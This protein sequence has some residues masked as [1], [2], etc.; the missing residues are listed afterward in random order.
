MPA[1]NFLNLTEKNK[2]QEALKQEEKAEIRERILMF[3]LLNDGKTQQEIS[4]FI[5]CSLRTV[6][7]WCVHGD[8][9]NLE[10]LEDGRTKGNYRKA[11]AKYIESLL[12]AIERSPSEYNYEFG[13]WTAARLG[14]HLEQETGIS[15]SGSQ[16]ARILAQKK[17]VYIWGKYSLED[18]Q[19]R[20]LR[21]QFKEKLE[22]YIKSAKEHPECLQVWFWDEC[23]FSLRVI[24]RR[25]WT[26]KGKRK[27]IKGQRRR[28]R[29][30][31]MGALRHSDKKRWCFLV[32]KG[33]SL[34]FYQQVKNFHDALIH[35]W[36]T[37]GN[38]SEDFEEKSA[39]IVI[40]LDN[41]SFH[42]KQEIV[43]QISSDF[44]KLKLEY[45]PP[46]SPDYNLIELVWHSAKEYIAHRD[47]DSKEQLEKTVNRL[48]NEGD[49]II[50]WS[51]KVKNKGNAVNAI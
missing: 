15:L 39:Q 42:K 13:R 2:L 22:G 11:T 19:D 46:Y 35:E 45:L 33:D 16:I 40:I 41:A 50:Q 8:P 5:G 24:R 3:L 9:H 7:Y 28:G 25:A 43:N 6:A 51:K 36:I 27:Q 17:Y 31:V 49:L 14:K 10:S 21:K 48:L 38:K 32:D 23:G 29:V 20:E 12:F 26:K 1:K 30:N 34:T 44:P 47:F 4:E 18:K 37:A